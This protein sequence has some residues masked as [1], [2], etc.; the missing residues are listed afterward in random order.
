[1]PK[2][3]KK[4]IMKKGGDEGETTTILLRQQS[5]E[6]SQSGDLVSPSVA[7]KSVTVS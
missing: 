6:F 3:Q 4:E 5:Q 7:S 2:R 1:M